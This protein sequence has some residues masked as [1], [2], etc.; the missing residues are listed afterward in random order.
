MITMSYVTVKAQ[1]ITLF[2]FIRIGIAASITWSVISFL[3]TF[4]FK[5]KAQL[6]QF[7]SDSPAV[8]KSLTEIDP[9][10]FFSSFMYKVF[11]STL[12]ISLFGCLFLWIGLK[13]FCLLRPIKIRLLKP[14]QVHDP[15][16]D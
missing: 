12:S 8:Q 1:G 13:L 15:K 11:L 16:D 6:I 7:F 5:D 9:N 2:S 10:A 3:L 4:S 14:E